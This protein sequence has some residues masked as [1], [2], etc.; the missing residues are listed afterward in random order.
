MK[1]IISV[2]YSAAAFNIS[3]LLLRLGAG[4]ALLCWHGIPKMMHFAELQHKFEDPFGFGRKISLILTIFA[5]VFCSVFLILGLFTRLVTIPLL[6]VLLVALFMIHAPNGGL[7]EGE[8]ALFYL[9]PVVTLLFCGA[10][11]ISV[12]GMIGK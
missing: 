1:K 9:L 8:L 5:E 2:H 4:L 7:K 12:D 3:M 10:G 6:I 11:R